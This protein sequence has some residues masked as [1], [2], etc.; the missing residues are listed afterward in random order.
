MNLFKPKNKASNGGKTVELTFD[1]TEK[2]AL[3]FGLQ[4]RSLVTSNAR[5]TGL[6]M[7]QSAGATHFLFKGQQIGFGVLDAKYNMHL[8]GGTA[9][10][11][12][13]QVA[14]RMFGGDGLFVLRVAEGEYWL[15]LIRNGSPTSSDMF[16]SNSNDHDALAMAR[17]QANDI[18]DEKAAIVIYT[19]LENHGISGTVRL[20]SV[21]DILIG[22]A[23]NEDRLQAIPKAGLSIPKPVLIVAGIGIALMAGK[24]GMDWWANKKRME[25]EAL[26]QVT[27]EDP[28]VSWARAIAAWEATQLSPN[29]DGLVMARESLGL[30]PIFWD[31]WVLGVATCTAAPL[32]PSAK[33]RP[34][35]CSA[36]YDRINS[37]SKYNR[38]MVPAIPKGWSVVFTPLRTMQV[39]WS[40]E[41]AATP[42]VIA[43]L[44]PTAYHKVETSS[45][46]QSLLPALASDM[47]F[48]FVPVTIAPPLNAEGQ[49]VP[50]P[51]DGV[52][53]SLRQAVITLKSPLRSIDF[54]AEQKT[55]A[56]WSSI[57]ITVGSGTTPGLTSSAVTAEITGV[58]YAKN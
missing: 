3:A 8:S 44:K 48:A 15:A 2:N 5:A 19:N 53:S 26:N 42:L 9:I 38:D 29:V 56:D 14:A 23:S 33:V 47:S 57:A 58:I 25:L 55:P 30:L 35:S 52:A 49:P 4:W 6:K 12:A 28:A 46:F 39:S 32:Q 36:T 11:P 24:Q 1:H 41:Q 21:E 50:P 18:A 27:T 45:V 37:S 7:A 17:A 22:A 16:L 31:G 10:F 34:W 51:P 13:A 40:L 54:I 43:N 20:T